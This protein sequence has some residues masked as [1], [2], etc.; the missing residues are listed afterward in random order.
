M[1]NVGEVKESKEGSNRK[2]LDMPAASGKA[3]IV[4]QA[5]VS[6]RACAQ[7]TPQGVCA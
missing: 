3:P 4:T 2:S 5:R 7:Y 1:K 6:S